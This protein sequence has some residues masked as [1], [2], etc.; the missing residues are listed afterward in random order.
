M[1]SRQGSEKPVICFWAVLIILWR[2]VLSAA[3]QLEYHTEMQYT[4]TLSMVE[5]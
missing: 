3:V 5:Q 2:S 4:S 1:L